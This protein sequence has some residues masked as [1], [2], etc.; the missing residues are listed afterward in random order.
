MNYYNSLRYEQVEEFL[1]IPIKNIKDYRSTDDLGV[2]ASLITVS[3]KSGISGKQTY[4]ATYS[5]CNAQ[6]YTRPPLFNSTWK[7]SI[8]IFVNNKSMTQ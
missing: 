3:P 5:I 1:K 8:E 4:T 7:F 2:S 6:A